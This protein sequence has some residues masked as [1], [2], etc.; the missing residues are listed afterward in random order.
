MKDAQQKI[1]AM[2]YCMALGY[3]PH[4]E[5]LVRYT[6]DV[7]DA[8]CDLTD[9]DVYGVRPGGAAPVLRVIFDC[10]S[11]SKLSGINRALW[12]RGLVD[13]V[14]A[15]EAF[16]ILGKPPVEAHRLA[17]NSFGVRIFS[18]TLFDSFAAAASPDYRLRNSYLESMDAWQKLFDAKKTFPLLA[19][20][21]THLV[22]TAPLQRNSTQGLRTL[23][24][25]VRSV[26]GEL[27]PTK[28]VHRAVYNA[29]LTQLCMF[30]AEVVR[31]F[32][33]VFDPT[34]Q[35]AG[36][37]A[38]L[39]NFIWGG[40]ESYDL[41]QRLNVALKAQRGV[42]EPEP[43]EFPAWERFV[44]YV[45]ACLDAPLAL[46]A[47]P[48]PIKEMA[49]RELSDDRTDYVDRR[50]A[51]RL[52]AND[53]VRQFAMQASVYLVDSAKLPREFHESFAA[54]LNALLDQ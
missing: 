24:S 1:K 28:P 42:N 15:T 16:V 9:I 49:F 52:K 50:L 44:D 2:R 25:K 29:T 23:M 26:R 37:E 51:G 17:G 6:A 41:R 53:R 8:P 39:R 21:I 7:G 30:V 5:V 19:D 35:K 3:V 4:L 34:A 10:K 38:V 48:L 20:Y 18:E 12:A 32:N 11:S 14:G 13:F 43:L 22:S 33:N 31:D 46:G 27:D 54:E 36:F 45:R 40:K 47:V